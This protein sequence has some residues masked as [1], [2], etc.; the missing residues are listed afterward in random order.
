[1]ILLSL[2]KKFSDTFSNKYPGVWNLNKYNYFY[3]SY[4]ISVTRANG[5]WLCISMQSFFYACVSWNRPHE[6]CNR[7]IINWLTGQSGN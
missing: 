1:M 5:L 2:T 6:P 3:T 4:L 7:V